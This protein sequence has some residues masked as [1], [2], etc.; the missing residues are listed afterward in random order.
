[1]DCM[2]L[3]P[4]KGEKAIVGKKKA[5]VK[6]TQLLIS[7]FKITDTLAKPQKSYNVNISEIPV[8]LDYFIEWF[9]KNVIEGERRTY[10]LMHF[11][12]DFCN[13]LITDLLNEICT[14]SFKNNNQVRFQTSTIL[15]ANN[16]NNSPINELKRFAAKPTTI[17]D[18]SG[19]VENVGT[20]NTFSLQQKLRRRLSTKLNVVGTVPR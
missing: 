1:M 5:E 16:L 12:R 7:C 15:A 13:H 14:R 3:A 9:T 8:A 6:N 2:Y 18:I 20:A 11:M 4:N 10:A 19:V 17:W